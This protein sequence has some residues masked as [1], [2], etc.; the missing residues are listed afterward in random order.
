MTRYLSDPLQQEIAYLRGA[1]KCAQ[2]DIRST[3]GDYRAVIEQCVNP[4]EEVPRVLTMLHVETAR[5][6]YFESRYRETLNEI[7][8]FSSCLSLCVSKEQDV[9]GSR[10]ALHFHLPRTTVAFPNQLLIEGSAEMRRDVAWDSANKVTR[11]VY[12]AVCRT[13]GVSE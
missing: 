6:D 7:D 2:A 3:N 1:L 11:K 12:G 4:L 9:M 10:T 13:L 8:R 5:A